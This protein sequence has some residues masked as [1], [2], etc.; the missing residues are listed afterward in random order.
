MRLHP[1]LVRLAS[2]ALVAAS[3]ATHAQTGAP[4]VQDW[5]AVEQALGRPGAALPGGVMRFKFP[6]LDLKVV[7][8]DV[9]V[10]PP[11][12]L[13]GW[14]SFLPTSDGTLV[15]G[16]LVLTLLE[17][18]P[19]THAL[20][21]GGIFITASHDHLLGE[22]PRLTFVHL[23]ARGDTTAI[24]KTIHDAIALSGTPL[25]L[26]PSTQGA[27]AYPL[28]TA[29]IARA[30]GAPGRIEGGVYQTSVPRAS[31]PTFAGL[32]LPPGMGVATAINI[33]PVDS[34][35]V[36]AAGD[37]VVTAAES[38]AVVEALA[39]HGVTV[40]AVHAHFAGST[41]ALLFVHFWVKDSAR[42]VTDGLR[43]ALA[44]AK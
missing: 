34:T 1:P 36:V 4:A 30:L 16:D 43:E 40:T 20:E 37:F 24:A 31:A 5:S 10:L 33:E 14:V 21:Q 42:R 39:A 7:V 2:L 8:G 9:P 38:Q 11:L 26:P 18:A 27:L 6:R 12:A 15:L 19:V 13:T 17:V 29:A 28:D 41:P 44:A 32:T 25:T 35:F 3:I 22:T 23:M